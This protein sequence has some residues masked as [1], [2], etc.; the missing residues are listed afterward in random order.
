MNH[1]SMSKE[2]SREA[3]QDGRGAR[4]TSEKSTGNVAMLSRTP[5][6]TATTNGCVDHRQ[7]RYG[8]RGE[9]QRQPEA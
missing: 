6:N 7:R 5:L 8:S 3:L 9:T 1:T 2:T 4:T